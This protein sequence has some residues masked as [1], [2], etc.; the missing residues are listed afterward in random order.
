M[1]DSTSPSDPLYHRL[2]SHPGMVVDL[3]RAFLEP[4]LLA[5]LDLERLRRHN[6]KFT[7]GRGQ[8][9][10]GDVVWEIPTRRGMPLFVL[11]MLEFQS[12]VEEWMALRIAVYA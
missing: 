5:E 8:R 2:F 6:T 10:R 4:A 1:T 3:L 9:R 11:L 12:E 7:A